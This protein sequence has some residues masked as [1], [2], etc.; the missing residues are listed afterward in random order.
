MNSDPYAVRTHEMRPTTAIKWA[1]REFSGCGR[2]KENPA[3]LSWTLSGS[4]RAEYGIDVKQLELTGQSTREERAVQ[5][6]NLGDLQRGPLG[7]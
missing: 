3:Q 6:R 7:I 1:L 4:H 5:S 2:G